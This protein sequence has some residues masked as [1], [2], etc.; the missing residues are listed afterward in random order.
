MSTADFVF[1]FTF[2]FSL[3]CFFFVVVSPSPP[4]WFVVLIMRAVRVSPR[5]PY[6]MTRTANVPKT[7][8]VQTL[9][10]ILNLI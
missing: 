1:D 8:T 9:N 5:W 3:F 4:L 6:I 2:F 10:S 7:K